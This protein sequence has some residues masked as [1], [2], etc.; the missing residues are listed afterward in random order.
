MADP[1]TLIN[2]FEVP[3]DQAGMSRR[4]KERQEFLPGCSV[5]SPAMSTLRCTRRSPGRGFPV[6]EHR[7]LD[8][9]EEFMAATAKPRLPRVGCGSGRVSATPGS[10]PRGADLTG[11][12]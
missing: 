1:L 12:K 3:S 10:V 7:P 2:A 4:I 11:W 5:R 6:G 8:S 9:A